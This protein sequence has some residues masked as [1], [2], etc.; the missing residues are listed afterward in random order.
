MGGSE[1]TDSLQKA[2]A[3]HDKSVCFSLGVNGT[4][5]RQNLMFLTRHAIEK[6]IIPSLSHAILESSPSRTSV[7]SRERSPLNHERCGHICVLA[8]ES[9]MMR[10]LS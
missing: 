2:S 10:L 8:P 9:R 6:C 5:P 3:L 1:A 7:R 4:L